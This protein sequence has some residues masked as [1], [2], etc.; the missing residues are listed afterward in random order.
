M[1]ERHE[2]P[3]VSLRRRQHAAMS[4]IFYTLRI[5][6]H[7]PMPLLIIDMLIKLRRHAGERQTDRRSAEAHTL[8]VSR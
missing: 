8:R 7:T 6:R 3:R 4:M 2:L 5:R 1:F